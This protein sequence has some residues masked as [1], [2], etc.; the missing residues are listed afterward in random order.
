MELMQEKYNKYKQDLYESLT[1]EKIE[2]YKNKNDEL[3]QENCQL[4][5]ELF[6]QGETITDLNESTPYK[7]QVDLLTD[8]IEILKKSIVESNSDFEK[9]R[10]EFIKKERHCKSLHKEL[11]S[12]IEYYILKLK[13]HDE[14]TKINSNKI[15]SLI[16]IETKDEYES[17]ELLGVYNTFDLVVSAKISFYLSKRTIDT[18]CLKINCISNIDKEER[19]INVITTDTGLIFNEDNFGGTIVTVNVNLWQTN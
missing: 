10:Q 5:Q 16:Y 13:I 7:T 14:Y 9:E 15:F 17:E 11:K 2:T 4:Q 18:K 8:I 19:N 6:L 1:N 3:Y 12:N